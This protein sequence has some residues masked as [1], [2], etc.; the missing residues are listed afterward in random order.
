MFVT[1]IVGYPPNETHRLS[2]ISGEPELYKHLKHECGLPVLDVSL[3]PSGGGIKHCVI[4]IKKASPWQ[5]WQVLNA[6]MGY[7][8]GIAKIAIVVD[9]DINPRDPEA[10]NWALA[11]A[12]QPHRDI[13]IVTHRVPG[14]DPAAYPPG[15]PMEERRFPFPSGSSS[16]LIDATRKWA[17]T[18][19]G[20]PRKEFMEQ[21][22]EIWEK[23]GL[24][25]LQLRTPWHG[26]HL[27]RWTADDEENA[28]LTLKGEHFK[29]AEKLKGRRKRL[30]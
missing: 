13:R 22:L 24:P 19:V 29:L 23:E 4:K 10:V 7:D 26:Y 12:M 5:P 9:E 1:T 18:P 3:P 27:G 30:S 14:L 16:L 6:L 28:E 17:Y 21:A 2:G 11:F 25:Q 20:L 8:P 15:A